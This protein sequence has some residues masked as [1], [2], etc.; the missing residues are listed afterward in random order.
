MLTKALSGISLLNYLGK[1]LE[2]IFTTR[3]GYL[4]STS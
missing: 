3:L 1:T 4:A 2:K